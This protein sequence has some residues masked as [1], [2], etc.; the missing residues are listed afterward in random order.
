MSSTEACS[1]Y[2]TM[3]ALAAF[4]R[5]LSRKALRP[6]ARFVRARFRASTVVLLEGER[7]SRRAFFAG[8]GAPTISS[9][10][11]ESSSEDSSF[12]SLASVARAAS[13]SRRASSSKRCLMDAASASRFASASWSAAASSAA[14][15]SSMAAARFAA[16]SWASV[17]ATSSG[18]F[19]CGLS[20]VSQS[21][22]YSAAWACVVFFVCVCLSTPAASLD[23]IDA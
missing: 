5:N 23:A 6:P 14:M 3:P 7:L 21:W 12:I 8:D 13:S 19:S 16:S 15:A 11:S 17:S 2:L 18:S 9:S 10:T 1:A 22:A 20:S 4:A